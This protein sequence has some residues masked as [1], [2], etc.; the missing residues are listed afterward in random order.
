MTFTYFTHVEPPPPCC[1]ISALLEAYPAAK[2][3][4]AATCNT[5]GTEWFATTITDRRVVEI[6]W[7]KKGTE[8]IR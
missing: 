2:A 4:D 8:V 3:R 7:R 1:S 6:T 5:C